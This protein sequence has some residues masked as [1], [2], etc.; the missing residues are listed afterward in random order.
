MPSLKFSVTMCVYA[1]DNS[2][3]F[4]KALESLY[5]QT[6]LPDELVLV[7]DGP[8]GNELNQVIN[9]YQQKD[10]VKVVRLE[11]NMGHG[12]ARHVSLTHCTHDY[13]AIADADDINR[14]D[15]FEKQIRCFQEDETLSVVGSFASH[16]NTENS[17]LYISKYCLQDFKIKENL[18]YKCPMCNASTMLKK[19]DVLKVGGYQDWYHAEDYY[20]WVRM[21][22]NGAVFK[23]LSEPLVNVRTSD[24]QILRRKGLRYFISLERLFRYMYKKKIIS[25]WIYLLNT[26]SRFCIQVLLPAQAVAYIRRKY[27]DKS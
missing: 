20:L 5:E 13:V 14:K 27:C 11:K 18:K 12:Y 26:V 4:E 17:T 23:N 15:R 24:D 10:G 16:F 19:N 8:V 22:L 21:F 1:K 2:I 6:C 25:L 3:W 7:V 9:K